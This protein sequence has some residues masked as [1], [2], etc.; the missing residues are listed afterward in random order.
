MS[1]SGAVDRASTEADAVS[2]QGYGGGGLWDPTLTA[3]FRRPAGSGLGGPPL[4]VRD[5]SLP[6]IG[7]EE[8]PPVPG[9][10]FFL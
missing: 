9:G 3:N 1:P 2:S 7:E 4:E 6:L 10:F 8:T 5:L